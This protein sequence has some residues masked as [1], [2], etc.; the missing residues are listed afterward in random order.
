MTSRVPTVLTSRDRPHAASHRRKVAKTVP[1]R[2]QAVSV[3]LLWRIANPSGRCLL[4]WHS[5]S[6]RRQLFALILCRSIRLYKLIPNPWDD[7]LI[8]AM[9]LQPCGH[10]DRRPQESQRCCPSRV[11]VD[12]R[13]IESVRCPSVSC[14]RPR[15]K[16]IGEQVIGRRSHEPSPLGTDWARQGASRLLC[17]QPD[18]P[19]TAISRGVCWISAGIRPASS[20]H[21]PCIS[22]IRL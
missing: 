14:A 7:V 22:V 3:W 21:R 1:R 2:R 4:M 18:R 17:G 16:P 6:P 10:Q 11:P 20:W 12:A 15:P 5:P 9:C 8:S 13:I 19:R